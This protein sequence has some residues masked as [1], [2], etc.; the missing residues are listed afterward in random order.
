MRSELIK[1]EWRPVVG[2]TG[3]Y[4]ASNFG[5][6]RSLKYGKIRIL[7]PCK[8]TKGYLHVCLWKDGKY[9]YFLVHRLVWEIFN[10]PIP[11]GY[12]INH[13]DENVGNNCLSNLLAVS[14]KTNI[15]WGT[16]N[17]RASEKLTN[18]KRSQTV[19]QLTYPGLEF[20]CEW[21][22]TH[23]AGRYGFDQSAVSACCRGERKSH[24][25]VTFRY[26]K[27]YSV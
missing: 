19:L 3:L 24:K 20:M 16:R 8:N 25:G 5:R 4:D 2:Y 23:E 10:G 14:H 18:G 9:K 1:E 26:K 17:Q 6:V 21:P 15:N 11:E 27:T 13:I 22:S 7:K 12:E